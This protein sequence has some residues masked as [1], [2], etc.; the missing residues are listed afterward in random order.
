MFLDSFGAIALAE[1]TSKELRAAT[2][3]RTS[4]LRGRLS[5]GFQNWEARTVWV[6]FELCTVT[7]VSGW[8]GCVRS[9]FGG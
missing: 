2:V 4:G 1:G 8:R 3:N 7:G 6:R 5:L 9:Q